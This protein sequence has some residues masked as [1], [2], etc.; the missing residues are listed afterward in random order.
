MF[1]KKEVYFHQVLLSTERKVPFGGAFILVVLLFVVVQRKEWRCSCLVPFVEDK[2]VLG[3]VVGSG[4]G[5]GAA[6]VDE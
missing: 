6:V 1:L 2:W 5:G 4:G 3:L